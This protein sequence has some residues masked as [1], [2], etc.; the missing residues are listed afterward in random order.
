VFPRHARA[1][2]N[3]PFS[4]RRVVFS[5]SRARARVERGVARRDA[6]RRVERRVA[7]RSDARDSRMRLRFRVDSSAQR[8]ARATRGARR[9]GIR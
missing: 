2:S 9:A 6:A 4:A 8:R 1:R 7:R 5:A 3:A